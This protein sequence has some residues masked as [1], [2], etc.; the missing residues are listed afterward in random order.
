MNVKLTELERELYQDLDKHRS[1]KLEGIS[2]KYNI[3]IETAALTYAR[4][5]KVML[6]KDGAR[7]CFL[8]AYMRPKNTIDARIAG[9][10]RAFI[11]QVQ[12]KE[13]REIKYIP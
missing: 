7:L 6:D 5:S 3:D 1:I 12:T 10:G 4:L 8:R 9:L 13:E 2:K 11:E